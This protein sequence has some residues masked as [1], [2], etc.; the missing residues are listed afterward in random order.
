MMKLCTFT[1]RNSE[2]DA[3]I[4]PDTYFITSDG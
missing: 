3:K 2:Q 4:F 1:K